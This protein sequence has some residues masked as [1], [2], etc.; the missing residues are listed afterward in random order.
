M[1]RI[2]IF[3]IFGMA[4]AN[5]AQDDTKRT[6]NVA[7][8]ERRIHE[9]T[10]SE[11]VHQKR[12]PLKVDDRL[13]AIAQQH[14]QDMARRKFF[15][16]INPDGKDPT[17]RGRAAKYTCRKYMLEFMSEGLAENIFQNNLYNRV[18]IRGKDISFEWNTPEKIAESTIN[19]WMSSPGHRRNILN[20]RYDRAGIGVAVAS[21]DQVLIT[22]L[23][24]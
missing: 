19:G 17:D 23:F 14:S 13:S 4:T 18:I 5:A 8:L 7:D 16:H 11:R 21:N 22:Q 2:L 12:R 6:L 20:A 15:D 10:N 3:V 24:C 9:L 1:L